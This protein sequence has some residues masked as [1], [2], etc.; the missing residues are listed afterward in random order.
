MRAALCSAFTGPE[1]L[2]IG[3]IDE[4][5]PTSDEILIDVYVASVSFMDQLLVS[6][7]YQM[8]PPTPF[9]SGTEAAGVVIAVGDKVTRFQRGDRV[10]CGGWT[11]GTQR[12]VFWQRDRSGAAIGRTRAKRVGTTCCTPSARPVAVIFPTSVFARRTNPN[13]PG[14]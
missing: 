2:R 9:V 8:R 10:A 3:E 6:G 4:P 1:D 12:Q 13:L 14:S 5:K 7:L 11:G